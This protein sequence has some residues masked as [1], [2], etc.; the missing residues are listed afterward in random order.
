MTRIHSPHLTELIG[1]FYE[2]GRSKYNG[3]VYDNVLNI[4]EELSIEDQKTLLRG[5]LGMYAA[6][7]TSVIHERELID[8][9]D[10]NALLLHLKRTREMETSGDGLKEAVDEASQAQAGTTK[11]N[12][13]SF[14]RLI[15][16]FGLSVVVIATMHLGYLAFSDDP[17]AMSTARMYSRVFE[18]FFQ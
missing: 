10:Y 4:F 16:V 15:S 14:L 5:T 13:D 2:I 8:Q 18:M 12:S 11:E 6:A 7:T 1:R 3:R 9:G 17:E